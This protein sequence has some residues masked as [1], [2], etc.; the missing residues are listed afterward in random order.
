MLPILLEDYI[1]DYSEVLRAMYR[2]ENSMYVISDDKNI[3]SANYKCSTQSF[4]FLLNYDFISSSEQVSLGRTIV[5]TTYVLTELGKVF[6]LF[7]DLTQYNYAD[8]PLML[9]GTGKRITKILSTAEDNV[10]SLIMNSLTAHEKAAYEQYLRY[11]NTTLSNTST[12]N[13]EH[14]TKLIAMFNLSKELGTTG[15]TR[16]NTYVLKKCMEE[17]GELSVE[18][19]IESGLSYKT[20]GSDGVS[21]EAVDLAICAM[22]MFAL[23]F[24]DKTAQEIEVLFLDKM[25]QKLDKWKK[26]L[27]DKAK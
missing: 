19:L 3:I 23:Q 1:M 8:S 13:E 15:D 14:S 27:Q 24:P 25:Q 5:C 9:A 7:E 2:S 18:D 10:K 20:A 22:D 4:E 12:S 16:T 17:L 26:T 11:C 6:G 21:G